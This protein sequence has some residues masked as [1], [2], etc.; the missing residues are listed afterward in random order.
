MSQKTQTFLGN[1]LNFPLRTDAR[2]QVALV[3]GAED[4]E[5]SIRIILGT[6]PGERVMRPTFGCRAHEL[7][8]EPRSA[9][10]ASLMQEYVHQSLRM[11]EPRIEVKNVNVVFD[12]SNPGA[13][14]A[15]IEYSIKATHD[16]RSIVYPFFIEDEQEVI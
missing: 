10:A 3:T 7:L 15:E 9:A 2:G 8:F 12:D 14:L 1:G 11:W 13:L 4:I 5:Q 6:R 16:T